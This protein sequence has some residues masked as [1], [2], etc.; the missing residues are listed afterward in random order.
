MVSE[1]PGSCG[2]LLHQ[3]ISFYT[4]HYFLSLQKLS[5]RIAYPLQA[6]CFTRQKKKKTTWFNT[7]GVQPT[8]HKRKKNCK[9]YVT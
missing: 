3:G 4:P 8:L 9:S 2:R 7:R 6:I 5:S 1:H